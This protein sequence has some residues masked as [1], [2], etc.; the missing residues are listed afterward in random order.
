MTIRAG[1][2]LLERPGER[3]SFTPGGDGAARRLMIDLVHGE[4][5]VGDL[6]AVAAS[7][8]PDYDMTLTVA[9]G[10]RRA[11]LVDIPHLD[12]F[13]VAS[14]V[15]LEMRAAKAEVVLCG[16]YP[17]DAVNALVAPAIAEHMGAT[18][19]SDVRSVRVTGA[20]TVE[21]L[22]AARN[23]RAEQL[24]LRLPVVAAASER[25]T[26]PETPPF[27]ALDMA[28][29]VPVDVRPRSVDGMSTPMPTN[30]EHAQREVTMLPG[31]PVQAARALLAAL[32]A[33]RR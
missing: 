4:A 16:G 18:F 13:A 6:I 3:G 23:G 28:A 15:A 2:C 11:V 31:E 1:V 8:Q 17:R 10:A 21:V 29:S 9:L 14:A 5:E 26:A 30:T 19:V 12:P 33:A 7:D 25:L 20:T 24:T 22:R 32:E 27:A